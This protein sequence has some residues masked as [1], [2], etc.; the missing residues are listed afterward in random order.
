M[1]SSTP[2]LDFVHLVEQDAKVLV[3]DAQK[4]RPAHIPALTPRQIQLLDRIARNETASQTK[5]VDLTNIDRSTLADVMRR[6]SR[7]GL[8]K[9]TR[10]KSDARAYNLFITESGRT[11]LAFAKK[12]TARAEKALAAKYPGLKEAAAQFKRTGADGS[13]L[14]VI[15]A[16]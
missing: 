9:R 14:R 6:L 7:A 10:N 3:T 16:E 15:A 8:I 1:T 4:E 13:G 11:A 5:I 2:L 12:A